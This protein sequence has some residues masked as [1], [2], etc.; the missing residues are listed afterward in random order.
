VL[1]LSY[2]LHGIGPR[3]RAVP[4][5]AAPLQDAAGALA[6]LGERH[7]VTW[8]HSNLWHLVY[9]ATGNSLSYL[10][11]HGTEMDQRVA[12]W[13]GDIDPRTARLR[14]AIPPGNADRLALLLRRMAAE[15]ASPGDDS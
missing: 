9:L 13:R 12:W 7:F 4:E 11:A 6:A 8:T 3:V 10:G 2:R 15:Q 1:R 5:G 14:T